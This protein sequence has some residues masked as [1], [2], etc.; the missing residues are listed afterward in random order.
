VALDDDFL[1]FIQKQNK[2]VF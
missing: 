2:N 1:E